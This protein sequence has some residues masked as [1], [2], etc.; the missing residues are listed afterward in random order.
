MQLKWTLKDR[1]KRVRL[2]QARAAHLVDLE[3]AG[4]VVAEL[5]LSIWKAKLLGKFSKAL[6]F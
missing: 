5:R 6:R 4:Q 3:A 2:E 1:G